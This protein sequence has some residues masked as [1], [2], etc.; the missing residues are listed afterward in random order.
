MNF[1]FL[2]VLAHKSRF[3]K[4]ASVFIPL[5]L[6]SSIICSCATIGGI[7]EK[8]ICIDRFSNLWMD[9]SWLFTANIGNLFIS[10]TIPLKKRKND[11]WIFLRQILR[12]PDQ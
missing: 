9:I 5:D 6:N 12:S 11:N 7:F 4:G 1:F 2:I 8:I 10:S 3:E